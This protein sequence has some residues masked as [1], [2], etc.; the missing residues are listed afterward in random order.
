V[1]KVKLEP[2][3]WEEKLLDLQP[4]WSTMPYKTAAALSDSFDN[5]SRNKKQTLIAPDQIQRIRAFLSR[6]DALRQPMPSTGK[7]RRTR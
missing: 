6:L 5:M 3:D 7:G 2:T 1:F 4:E